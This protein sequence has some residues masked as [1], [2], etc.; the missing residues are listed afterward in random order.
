[1][2]PKTIHWNVRLTIYFRLNNYRYK[3]KSIDYKKL[4]LVEQQFHSN[5]HD[6]NRD[7]KFTT[8]NRKK[9]P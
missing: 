7:A 2:L 6:I 9:V 3:I 8:Y 5:E 1:M 4:I